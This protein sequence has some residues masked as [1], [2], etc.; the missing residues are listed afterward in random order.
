LQA[1]Q[2]LPPEIREN[3]LVLVDRSGEKK[4]PSGEGL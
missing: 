2:D 3:D 4:L 1:D